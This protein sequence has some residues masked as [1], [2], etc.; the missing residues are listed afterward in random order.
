M[1]RNIFLTLLAVAVFFAFSC[2]KEQYIAPTISGI[3]TDTI[4]LNI[5]DEM[6]L[7]PNITNLK[8]NIYAWL[9]N[10]K[11]VA[12]DQVSYTFKATEP[13]NFNVTFKANNKAGTAEQSFKIFVE[14]PIT[15]SVPG[16]LS[17]SLST[18]IDIT[19]E[20]S[21]PERNDYTY[22]WSIGDSVIS[23]KSSLTF[24][25]P[26]AGT[27]P[28]TLKV[29]A[30]KQSASSTRNIEVKTAQY[31]KNAYTVLEY[32]PAPGKLHNWAIIGARDLW[33]LGLEH[34]LPYNDFL[35]KASEI[36]KTDPFAALFVGAWGGYA[37]FKFD[38][39]VANV[40]GKTDLELTA[41]YSNK[42][43]PAVYVAYDRNKNGK[44]DEEEWYEIKTAD[45]GLEDSGNY[46]MTFTLDS[47]KTD[48]RRAYSYHSY[49]DN[50]DVPVKGQIAYNK[51][52]TSAMT[53]AGTF[54]VRGFFP[55]LNMTDLPAKKMGMLSGWPTSFTR[56]GKRL[57]KNVTGAAP[58]FQNMN[59]D[60]DFAVNSKGENVELPGIDF[61]K[62]RKV[63]YPVQQVA[64]LTGLQDYNLEEGRML[65]VRSI[66]DK[67]LK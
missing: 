23:K 61:V 33:D 1:N 63:V 6:E 13:G 56:S 27:F 62:V 8:G 24:I 4:T 11:E 2:K 22:V 48:D 31:V 19:P 42:D 66:L 41:F 38:H 10:G 14:K 57:T 5:G 15:V 54:S 37:T 12:A 47:F 18:V 45:Y 60:I 55:G 39:T 40:P 28:L 26:E 20:V 67:H 59:I 7:A 46:A 35:A 65:Q 32:A 25:S 51:T 30:G 17:V 34:P 64:G 49:K 3:G 58:F 36:R 53:Y 16:E 43:L 21:G 9:V 52:F 44:P 50:Q 29:T